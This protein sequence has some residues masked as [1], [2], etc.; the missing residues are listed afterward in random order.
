M[1]LASLTRGDATIGHLEPGAG[2][3]TPNRGRR[4][5]LM[6][7]TVAGRE[8]GVAVLVER[9]HRDHA[10]RT[11]EASDATGQAPAT[12][13]PGQSAGESAQGQPDEPAKLTSTPGAKA[14]GIS[15][16]GNQE[17]PTSLVIVPWKTSELGSSIGI[18]PVLDDSRQ[19]V[20]KDVFM[21]ALRY[22]EIS[23]GATRDGAAAGGK[24]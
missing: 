15:I 6:E 21:R 17:A 5:P 1:G 3:M 2:K 22:H 19:P 9:E 7:V 16:L 11:Q 4:Q 14:L 12:P 23:S 24:K 8:I 13:P 10:A 18:S 20:D